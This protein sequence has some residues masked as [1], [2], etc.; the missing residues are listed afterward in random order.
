MLIAGRAL[1]GVAGALLVPSTL[2][3]IVANFQSHDRGAAIG[4]WTAWTG[5]ATVIG[6]LGGGLILE[7][8]SWR[9]IF[10]IN[11]IPIAIALAIVGRLSAEHDRPAGGRVDMLGAFLCAIGLGGTVFALIEQ[12]NYGFGDP[13]IAIP[14]IGGLVAL[15]AFVALRAPRLA[16][17]ASTSTCS[18]T[19]TSRSATRRR[20]R[21]TPGS[22]ACCS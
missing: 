2:G 7:N 14:L 21:S 20:S 18:A 12:P 6:P 22:A 4:T 5:V 9:W 8:A 17:D 3:L 11:L 1:Q 10:A 13:L 15:V 16:S 19:A